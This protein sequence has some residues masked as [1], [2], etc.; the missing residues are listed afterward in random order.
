MGQAAPGALPLPFTS[1]ALSPIS[2][3]DNEKRLISKDAVA[4]GGLY[5][6]LT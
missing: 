6:F 3:S 1:S 4:C 5:F 2:N